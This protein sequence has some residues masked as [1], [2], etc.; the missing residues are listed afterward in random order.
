MAQLQLSAHSTTQ[1][2]CTRSVGFYLRTA[3]G[4]RNLQLPPICVG[5]LGTQVLPGLPSPEAT[6]NKVY[7]PSL[8]D[9]ETV[10]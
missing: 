1:M 5:R 2:F 4:N 3:L 7:V 6:A 8:R 10:A 9:C